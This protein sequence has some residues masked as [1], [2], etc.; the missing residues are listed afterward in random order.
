MGASVGVGGLIIGISMLVVFSMAVTT[1]NGQMT[2][3]LEVIESAQNSNPVITINNANIIQ[4]AVNTISITDGGGTGSYED[5]WL[6]SPSC[7]GF[8]ASF[9]VLAGVINSVDV[10]DAGSCSETP[11]DMTVEDQDVPVDPA[12]VA[13]FAVDTN[14]HF[15]ANVT[16][17][18]PETI[19]TNSAWLFLD[20][21]SP[22]TLAS[23]TFINPNFDNWFSGETI[24]MFWDDADNHNRITV[25]VGGTSVSHDIL[26]TP[27]I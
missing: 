6:T 12:D 10:V 13:E 1:L 7:T 27:P 20:G 15:F 25:S 5:G 22:Q 9:T 26:S 23:S 16:N 11:T 3:S 24:F 17:D 2:T 18:G 19:L 8:N 14:K 21:S 4:F